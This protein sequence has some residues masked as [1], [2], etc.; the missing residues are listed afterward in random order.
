MNMTEPSNMVI[1]LIN[2]I[3]FMIIQTIFFKYIL[4]EKINSVIADKTNILNMY[5]QHNKTLGAKIEQ[6]INSEHRHR[7]KEVAQ[8]QKTDRHDHNNISANIWIFIP[9]IINIVVLIYFL[10]KLYSVP[11]RESI[12]KN[13]GYI[14]LA[15][16][17][18]LY[19]LCMLIFYYIVDR[20]EYYGDHELFNRIYTTVGNNVTKTCATN[21]GEKLSDDIKKVTG[22]EITLMELIENHPDLATSLFDFVG[23][24]KHGP[25]AKYMYS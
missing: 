22:S 14:L 21:S 16:P 4:S 2:I 1:I 17:V 11:N 18:I 3:F 23:T 24:L 25:I 19:T 7:L 12:W 9:I 10:H 15:A 8:K 20:H 13:D 6:Y 5:I